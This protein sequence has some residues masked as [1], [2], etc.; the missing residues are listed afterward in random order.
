MRTSH[1]RCST[2]RSA[3]MSNCCSAKPASATQLSLDGLIKYDAPSAMRSA[4]TCGSS[5]S[6]Q[7]S[8]PA[9]P[10]RVGSGGVEAPGENSRTRPK[11]RRTKS[12]RSGKYSM[13]GSRY[14]LS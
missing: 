14:C 6:L 11:R 12:R 8:T 9:S 13:N 10:A 2:A 7:I 5:A 3:T 1:A 4:A